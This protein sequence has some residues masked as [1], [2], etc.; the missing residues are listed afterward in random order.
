[1]NP[2]SWAIAGLISLCT[3]GCA[4]PPLEHE[5]C[6]QMRMAFHNK[7]SRALLDEW[8]E[9]ALGYPRVFEES[10]FL[11]GP[12]LEMDVDIGIESESLGL[13]PD[14]LVVELLGKDIDYRALREE[15]IEAIVLSYGYGYKLVFVRDPNSLVIQQYV[16]QS[17]KPYGRISIERL[18]QDTYLICQRPR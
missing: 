14:S 9:G 4:L 16:D 6:Q 11:T 5:E 13:P 3:A 18:D 15:S 1:M 10:G 8:V 17:K 7:E 2:L 12:L